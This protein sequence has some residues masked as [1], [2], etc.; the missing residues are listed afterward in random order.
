ML[1]KVPNSTD[2]LYK[3]PGERRS[4]DSPEATPGWETCTVMTH[5]RPTSHGRC[6]HDMPHG[7]YSHDSPEANPRREMQ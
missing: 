6:S 2:Q 7:R 3:A 1:R 5:P 4:H